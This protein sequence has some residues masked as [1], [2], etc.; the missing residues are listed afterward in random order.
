MSDSAPG[1][2]AAADSKPFEIAQHAR[3]NLCS[4]RTEADVDMEATDVDV[5]AYFDSF[6][7]DVRPIRRID[8]RCTQHLNLVCLLEQRRVLPA[9]R[10]CSANDAFMTALNYD[11][12]LIHNS[13]FKPARPL[14]RRESE[15]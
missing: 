6:R 9:E 12:D 1:R 4:V 7:Q 8:R 14:P 10:L 2:T 5:V 3:E 15:G 13:R 11:G